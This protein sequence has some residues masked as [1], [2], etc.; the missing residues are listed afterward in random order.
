ML[1]GIYRSSQ[2]VRKELP[3]PTYEA[4]FSSQVTLYNSALSQLTG[5]QPFTRGGKLLGE[6][7]YLIQQTSPTVV[8]HIRWAH[9]HVSSLNANDIKGSLSARIGQ[10]RLREFKISPKPLCLQFAIPEDL[11][12]VTMQ[13]DPSRTKAVQ[14]W[15]YLSLQ[16][17]QQGLHPKFTYGQCAHRQRFFRVRLPT[18]L[19]NT[20]MSLMQ[21][22]IST[23]VTEMMLRCSHPLLRHVKQDTK[24]QRDVLALHISNSCYSRAS[25]SACFQECK[26]FVGLVNNWE[27]GKEEP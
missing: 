22:S 21:S 19:H 5:Y 20:G 15:A 12:L 8:I 7:N 16:Q 10:L 23:Q 6:T 27:H 17:S 11:E 26:W 14:F 18:G 9:H 24:N 1:Q 13:R 2:E 4:Q 3:S 25:N